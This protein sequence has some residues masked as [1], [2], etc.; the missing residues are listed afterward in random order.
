MGLLSH[1][2]SN[3]SSAISQRVQIGDKMIPAR[4]EE[5]LLISE[6]QISIPISINYKRR[7]I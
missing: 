3:P 5:F 6:W 7:A 4:R 2:K 1:L